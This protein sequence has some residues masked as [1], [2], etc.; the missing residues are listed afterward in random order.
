MF[1]N[2]RLWS[3]G[4]AALLVTAGL[5]PGEAQAQPT[6]AV[7]KVTGPRKAAPG[8]F[9]RGLRKGLADA[10][11][12]VVKVGRASVDDDGFTDGAKKVGAEFL[13]I[14]RLRYARRKRFV[15]ADLYSVE[16]GERIKRKKSSYRSKKAASSVGTTVG[17]AFAAA[18][19]EAAAAA[20]E[21]GQAFVPP[22]APVE[23]DPAP[24]AKVEAPAEDGPGYDL[25]GKDDAM[26]R[27][28]VGVGT[29]LSSAYTVAVAGQV[30][31]LAYT[32]NPLLLM[33]VGAAVRVP[34]LDIGAEVYLTYVPVTFQVDVSP[35]VDPSDPGGRFM[36]VG[37]ALTYRLKLSQFGET[38]TVYLTPLVGVNY[39]SMTVEGQGDN[40]VVVSY[41]GVDLQGGLRLGVS[42]SS[43]LTI[44]IEGRGG[45]VLLYDE[46]PTNTGDGGS[47]IGLRFG[48]KARYWFTDVFGVYGGLDYSYQKV[49]LT[50][51][52]SRVAFE[53]DPQL[54]DA[55]VFSGSFRVF[56]GLHIAI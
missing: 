47:G 19:S 4:L 7:A 31:G 5:F 10:G 42:L 8:P 43:A 51:V 37:G 1:A 40:S 36:D 44:E 46:G 56:S 27:F 3:F 55:T 33:T 41:S 24:V 28:S 22:V 35:P 2:R 26:L 25:G 52:G 23:P 21:P 45:A 6:V 20:P 14:V 32:L 54:L 13:V 50:G 12:K 17:R 18:I 49:G 39:G 16:T 38:G 34:N 53:A 9:A 11:A 29:Q 30:T 48:A 15:T